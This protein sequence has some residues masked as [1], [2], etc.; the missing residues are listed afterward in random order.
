MAMAGLACGRAAQAPP[1]DTP[2]PPTPTHAPTP[3]PPASTPESLPQDEDLRELVLYANA[4][5]PLL[6]A[7]GEIL[8]RDGPILEEAEGGNDEVLCDGR[9]QADNVDMKVVID[10]VRDISAPSDATRIHELVVQS[11]DA[12]TEALDNIDQFCDT[13][14]ALFKV[15]AVLRFWE[16][17][18][19]LQ[20]AHNRFWALV[21]SEGVQDWVRR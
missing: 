2:L 7:A 14:N 9:L 6:V 8:E 18:L 12:W 10:Q 5:Q 16:A 1:T 20:D 21:I 4:L 11:G 15:P 19:A 3:I 17:G 13:G